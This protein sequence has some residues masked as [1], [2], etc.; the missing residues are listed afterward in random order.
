MP[1]K[2]ITKH[3]QLIAIAANI[4]GIITGIAL[5]TTFIFSLSLWFVVAIAIAGLCLALVALHQKNTR[6]RKAE[7]Q[8]LLLSTSQLNTHFSAWQESLENRSP[9]FTELGYLSAIL[10]DVQK[11]MGKDTTE[12]DA[13]IKQLMDAESKAKNWHANPQ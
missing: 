1:I 8:L 9:T 12:I 10:A 2:F 5:A 7:K 4:T 6:I 3:E 11:Q 13:F